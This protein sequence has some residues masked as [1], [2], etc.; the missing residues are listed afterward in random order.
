VRAIG[1]LLVVAAFLARP[2]VARGEDSQADSLTVLP[3]STASLVVSSK[4]TRAVV[5]L[6]DSTDCGWRWTGSVSAPLDGDSRVAAFT[7][8]RELVSGFK[9]TF[10]AGLDSD[11]A[12]L[13]AQAKWVKEV[14]VLMTALIEMPYAANG[15]LA[16][17][18]KA[19]KLA[20]QSDSAVWEWLQIRWKAESKSHT[21]DGTLSELAVSKAAT[22]VAAT[23]ACDGS[24]SESPDCLLSEWFEV[25]RKRSDTYPNLLR[26][27]EEMPKDLILPAALIAEFKNL[28]DA[29]RA[30]LVVDH[31]AKISEYL[32]SLQKEDATARLGAAMVTRPARAR[33]GHVLLGDVA[34]SLDTK[35]VYGGDLSTEATQT[36]AY[37]LVLGIDYSYLPTVAGLSVNLRGGMERSRESG[38]EEVERCETIDS[39]DP[40]VSGKDCTDVLFRSG[41][42]PDAETTGY[43]R[44]A[45]TYQLHGKLNDG[46]VLPGVELRGG[47]DG[48]LGTRVGNGRLSLFATPLKGD[49]AGRFGLAIDASYAIDRGPMESGTRWT[50]TSLVFVG[51]SFKDLMGSP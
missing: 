41:A 45:I 31:W 38:A 17:F 26:K 32:A 43:A 2:G 10:Q 16:R 3:W 39:D 44:G 14:G 50:I 29:A 34:F 24:V 28:P 6:S 22:I 21:T 15:R 19:N 37:D 51:A 4:D 12:V 11:R 30:Q 8:N 23:D 9:A 40:A 36:T 7:N 13:A 1:A 27:I 5:Q 48:L 18:A 20:S 42:Q 46:E 25:Q 49:T 35:S 47:I 33:A